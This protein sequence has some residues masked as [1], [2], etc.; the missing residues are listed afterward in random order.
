MTRAPASAASQGQI[1]GTGFAITKRIESSAMSATHSFWMTLGPGFDAAIVMSTPFIASGIPPCRPSPFVI[2]ASSHFSAK[3]SR[4]ASTSFRCRP[5]IPFESTSIRCAGLAPASIRSFAVRMFDAPAPISVIETSGS[6]LPT[7]LRALMTP[8]MLVVVPHRDLAFLPQ[9]VEDP[10]ALRLLDVLEVHASESGG[11]HLH[12]LDDLLRIFRGERNRERVDPAE[13]LEQE[14]L[15][16]HDRQAGLRS[17]V[18]QAENPRAVRHDRNLVP[19]VRQG[20]HFLGVRLDLQAGLGD[21]RRIPDREVV[22]RPDRNARHDL[23]LPL[24][25]GMELRRL[26]LR[27]VRSLQVL[28]DFLRRRLLHGLCGSALLLAHHDDTRNRIA[29]GGEKSCL[30]LWSVLGPSSRVAARPVDI[31][32][33]AP[34]SLLTSDDWLRSCSLPWWTGRVA[35]AS[36]R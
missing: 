27:K 6:F 5:T 22:E 34:E 36:R 16:F 26:F 10:E 13:I 8:A 29:G 9:S 33:P 32:L 14:G 15:P 35:E 25:V 4:A 3:D 19:L 28:F 21:S 12:R 7:T 17:D 11:D 23:D 1:S 20:P 18:P 2:W 30:N 24:V 31:P